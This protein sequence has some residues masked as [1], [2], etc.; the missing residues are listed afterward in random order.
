M[1]SVTGS[2]AEGRS[3]NVAWQE[4]TGEPLDALLGQAWLGA[5]HPDDRAAVVAAHHECG[6]RGVAFELEYRLR[7]ADGS[8]RWVL[9]RGSVDTAKLADPAGGDGARADGVGGDGA[10]ADGAGGDCVAVALDVTERRRV[11]RERT[12]LLASSSEDNARLASLQALT[13]SL[14]ALTRPADVAEVVLGRG[15]AELGAATGSLCLLGDDGQTMEVTAQVGYPPELTERWG[16][17]PLSS[18]TPAGDAIRQGSGIYLSTLDELHAQYPIFG[19]AAQVGDQAVAVLPLTSDDAGVLGAMVFGFAEAREF[20]PGERRLLDALAAQAAIALARTRSR[21]AL[22]AARA[23]LAFLADASE[24]LAASLDLDQT[25]ATTASLAVPRLADR[26]GVY[27]LVEGR[28]QSRMWAPADDEVELGALERWP[29]A[30]TDTTGIGAVLRTGERIFAP[31]I[32]DEMVGTSI[33]SEEQRQVLRQIGVGAAVIVPLRARGRLLG[34]LALVNRSGHSMSE[35]DRAVAD[36]LAARAAVAIDN[37]QLYATQVSLAHRLQASLLPPSLP[38]VEG[39]DLAARYAPAGDGAEVGG[40]F[41][42]CIRLSRNRLLLVV[43]DVQGKGVDAAGLT[44]MA[45][46]VIRAVATTKQRPADVLAAL[47][48]ALFRQESERSAGGSPRRSSEDA[49]TRAG[50]RVSARGGSGGPSGG[51]LGG[52]TGAAPGDALGAAEG[53]AAGAAE[54]RVAEGRSSGECDEPR[55]CTVLAVSLTRRGRDFHAVVASAGHPLPLLRSPDGQVTTIGQP[56][57]LL[58]ILPTVQL[59]QVDVTLTPG[60][61]LVCYTDGVS[62]CHEG[63]RFFDEEGMIAIIAKADG[64]AGAVAA[65]VEEAARAFTPGGVVKDD[66]AIL[67]VGVLG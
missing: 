27:L 50:G 60:S 21:A 67:A 25:L 29:V 12:D 61:L 59:P 56:G 3:F 15:V 10:G 36:E 4:F 49:P 2:G 26:C 47:N 34:A 7:A 19:G 39:L 37:A 64:P 52:P 16:R 1:V 46:H 58:G 20:S 9:S 44:G 57:Q 54:P 23:Q 62:E 22:E 14:A 32:D 63:R 24:R 42:D 41:Y 48:D 17:F 45:R 35:Q 8:F 11:E 38:V 53:A 33:R 51:A 43:G 31:T 40:D 28:V 55:F 65:A 66:M 18:A 13:S 5:V 30:L 6:V